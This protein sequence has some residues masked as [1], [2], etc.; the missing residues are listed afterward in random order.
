MSFSTINQST[1]QGSQEQN[2]TPGMAI[3]GLD[4]NNIF[5]ILKLDA[6]GNL[7][8]GTTNAATA[9]GSTPF[10]LPPGAYA[11]NTCLAFF[12]NLYSN[13][14]GSAQL[15][16]ISPLLQ[17]YF[18]A[19]N[20]LNIVLMYSG[21]SLSNY[22]GTRNIG[23][24]TYTPAITD[25]PGGLMFYH[26]YVFQPYGGA[27]AGQAIAVAAQPAQQTIVL[28]AATNLQAMIVAGGAVTNNG[29]GIYLGFNNFTY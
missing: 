13:T 4:A 24:D 2:C 25:L 29:N 20:N 19:G 10:P 8:P 28:P 1:P 22:S 11:V 14:S 3:G 16:K 21:S 9:L 12:N 23:V 5:R 27:G 18:T 15:I 7:I 17:G 26:N 6:N